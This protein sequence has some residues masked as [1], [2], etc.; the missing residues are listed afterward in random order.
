[1]YIYIYRVFP[2]GVNWGRVR[3]PPPKNLLIPTHLENFHSSRPLLRT[4]C[5]RPP[6]APILSNNL[7]V[8]T[9]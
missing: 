3:P 2:T 9:Q 8:I 4:K 7:Q 5:F 6:P 1:M